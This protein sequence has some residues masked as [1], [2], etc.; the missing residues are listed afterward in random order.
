MDASFEVVVNQV[1]GLHSLD[2]SLK[3][4]CRH[5]SVFILLISR[6]DSSEL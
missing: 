2:E 4:T 3:S 5:A 6:H 1:F